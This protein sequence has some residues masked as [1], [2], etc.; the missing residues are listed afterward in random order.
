[1]ESLHFCEKCKKP[2]LPIN[3]QIKD[4]KYY[5]KKCIN[6]NAPN[7]D[8]AENKDF[9]Q[10]RKMTANLK[11]KYS[12]N[13]LGKTLMTEVVRPYYQFKYKIKKSKYMDLVPQVDLYFHEIDESNA[14]EFIKNNGIDKIKMELSE[15]IGE[16]VSIIFENI[17]YGSLLINMYIFYK[18]MKSGGQKALKKLKELFT[19]K[20]EETKKA[21]EV[22]DV[23]ESHSFKCLENL[24]PNDVK[25]VNQNQ[26]DNK[27]NY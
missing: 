25:F 27:Q 26:L 18:K 6:P 12:K 20:K 16:D 3:E 11:N 15:I 19:H 4:N 8:K 13:Y 10:E 23:I 14:K 7:N 24:K 5:H 17:T 2:I 21:K 1:M 22:V 9:I